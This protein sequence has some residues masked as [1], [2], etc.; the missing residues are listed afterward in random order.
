[1][2]R[3]FV[4]QHALGKIEDLA[5][6]DLVVGILADLDHETV[7]T[8]YEALRALPGDLRIAILSSDAGSVETV[9]DSMNSRR[10][11]QLSV[12]PWPG[13][14]PDASS[15]PMQSISAAYQSIFTAGEV[16]RA[17]AG[18]LIASKLDVASPQW[19]CRLMQPV[20]ES[21]FDLAAPHYARRKFEGLLNS[22]I[23]SPLIRCL[24]GKR[25]QNPLG[26]DL[27]FSRP[28]FEVLGRNG[29]NPLRI[30]S[31]ASLAPVAICDQ[32]RICQVHV[33]HRLLP[34]T[35][36]TNIS[37]LL[38][39]A[40]GP[41]FLTMES[42]AACWQKTRASIPVSGFGDPLAAPH[43]SET[44]DVNRLVSSFQLGM[45]DL[46]EIW[47]LVLPPATLLELRKLARSTP[48]QFQMPDEL[49]VRIVYEFAL[50]HRLR[51]IS[52]EHLLRSMTPLYLGWV[53]GYAREMETAE[54]SVVERRLERLSDAYEASKPYLVSRWRWPDRFSP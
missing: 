32:L 19:V 24:Y 54:E 47:G 4:Q 48:E 7:A 38:V 20:L 31:L 34:P 29:R 10:G 28:L 14:G 50:A 13:T 26:P 22:S 12:V 35:D 30:H 41:V 39:Q 5:A 15:A 46:Q 53:A 27:G 33:G 18:C 21:G 25:L 36:W 44:I 8:V 3:D 49:W 2:E 52:R 23:I 9:Q 11:P 51:T 37:S 17:R 42:N 43:E 1:V 6:A 45:R 16:L 40:L